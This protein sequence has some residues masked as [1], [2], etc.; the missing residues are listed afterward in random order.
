MLQVTSSNIEHILDSN[1]ALILE[2]CY[3]AL[4]Y[5]TLEIS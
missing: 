5:S 3:G 2:K 4:S 1:S